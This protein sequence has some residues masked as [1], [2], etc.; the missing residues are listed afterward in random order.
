MAI[1]ILTIN[2][3]VIS[4]CV[5][6]NLLTSA[7]L[8]TY[9]FQFTHIETILNIRKTLLPFQ[10]SEGWWLWVVAEHKVSYWRNI[11]LAVCT[12]QKS[13]RTLASSTTPPS[14]CTRLYMAKV[15][16]FCYLQNIN[17]KYSVL[18]L[19]LVQLLLIYSS[20]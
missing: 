7:N 5:K 17:K 16:I 4:N 20:T 19:F 9:Q 12:A 10:A 13:V 15:E 8:T 1:I 11:Y 3:Y 14:S 18:K 2:Y 6:P